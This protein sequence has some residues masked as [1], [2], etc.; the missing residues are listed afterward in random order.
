MLVPFLTVWKAQAGP[1]LSLLWKLYAMPFQH[2]TSKFSSYS[3]TE[4]LTLFM[5]NMYQQNNQQ[6][7]SSLLV[8]L[9]LRLP[10]RAKHQQG[11]KFLSNRRKKRNESDRKSFFFNNR[12][13]KKKGE[14][15]KLK[16][17]NYLGRVKKHQSLSLN[18]KNI[19]MKNR[20][21]TS[22]SLKT[23]TILSQRSF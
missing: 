3:F 22:N 10:L 2:Q 1:T 12:R 4:T 16:S 23:L 17:R 5:K 7:K 14:E 6:N 8:N 19:H 20:N 21:T 18:P 9:I 15:R 11:R 13:K